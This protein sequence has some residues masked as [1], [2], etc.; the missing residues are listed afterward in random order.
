MTVALHY[1]SVSVSQEIGSN[2]APWLLLDLDLGWGCRLL[3]GL[4]DPLPAHSLGRQVGASSWL[5]ASVEEISS[6]VATLFHRG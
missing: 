1:L 6:M 2:L 4:Q 5:E 3:C